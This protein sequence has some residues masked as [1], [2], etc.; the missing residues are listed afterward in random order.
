[1]ARCETCGNDYE[2]TFQVTLGG[3]THTFDSFECA[4]NACA[5]KCAAC[6]VRVVGHGVE[7]DSGQIYCCHHCA[8]KSH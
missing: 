3:E 4:I 8:G 6:G 7:D 5:P 1:M 2:K